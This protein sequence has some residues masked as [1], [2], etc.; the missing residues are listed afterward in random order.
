MGYRAG[1]AAARGMTQGGGKLVEVVRLDNREPRARD[2]DEIEGLLVQPDLI[3][4]D[5][6]SL[7]NTVTPRAFASG[8]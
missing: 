3:D 4:A 5:R 7:A 6:T 2:G 1:L 8:R